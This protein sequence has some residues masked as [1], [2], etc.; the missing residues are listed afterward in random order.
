M[1]CAFELPGD[2]VELAPSLRSHGAVAQGFALAIASTDGVQGRLAMPESGVV[3][4]P[5]TALQVGVFGHR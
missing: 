3:G 1:F 4:Y 2:A 5:T